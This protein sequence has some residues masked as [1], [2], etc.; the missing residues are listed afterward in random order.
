MESIKNADTTAQGIK[1]AAINP[2]IH[3]T[4]PKIDD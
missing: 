4:I 2:L 3:L 1:D